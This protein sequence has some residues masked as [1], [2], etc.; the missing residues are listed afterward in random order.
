MLQE[1]IDEIYKVKTWPVFFER[2]DLPIPSEKEVF[3]DW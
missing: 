3:F 1:E 2:L